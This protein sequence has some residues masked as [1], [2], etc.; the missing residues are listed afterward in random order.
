MR[1]YRIRSRIMTMT[2]R[3]LTKKTTGL[4]MYRRGIPK[5]LQ[6]FYQNKTELKSSLQTY[7]EHEATK[8]A[9]RLATQHDQEF[10]KL[11]GSG[12]RELAVQFLKSFGLDDAPLDRQTATNEEGSVNDLGSPYSF[13]IDHF[14]D[15]YGE[16]E[17][18]KKELPHERRA[19]DILDGKEPVRLEEVKVFALKNLHDKKKIR[20]ANRSFAYFEDRLSTTILKDI[21][22]RDIHEI[23]EALQSENLS[24]LTVKKALGFVNKQTREYLTIYHQEITNPFASAK[25]RNI[26]KDS[27]QKHVFDN[28]DLLKIAKAVR[29]D[30]GN[31]PALIAG[32]QFNTGAR[33]GEIGGL[34]LTDIDLSND[35]PSIRIRESSNRGIKTK[36]SSRYIP[37]T[38][39]SLE[40][41]KAVI[42]NTKEG[43]EYAFDRYNKNGSYSAANCQQAVNKWLRSIVAQGTSHSFRH[44]LNDR[45]LDAGNTKLEI[46][47]IFGWQSAGMIQNYGRSNALN[48]LQVALQSIH[49]Y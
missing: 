40:V 26:G 25:V 1:G 15:T 18:R 35:I 6:Q 28:S 14:Y 46:D 5:D 32:L 16:G 49:Q 4:F 44:S 34:K 17:P 22:N 47:S 10:Q 23:V 7:N 41:A 33:V 13:L 2:V 9:I 21:R 8:K 48:R 45:L 43:Q 30:T 36:A 19:L 42:T 39:I 37:L 11:R 20:D 3:Y 24:T 29:E 38:G 12:E 31:P 27:I